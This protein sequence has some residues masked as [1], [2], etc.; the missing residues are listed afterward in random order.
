MEFHVSRFARDKYQFDSTL[1]SLEGN[2]I[3]ANFHAARIFAQKINLKRNLRQFPEN[4]IKASQLNAL[5]LIDEIFHYV[6]SLYRSQRNPKLFE[7]AYDY[8]A[9]KLANPRLDDAL[10]QFSEEFPVNDVYK[11]K[12]SSQDYL[13][14]STE[15]IPNKAVILEELLI[16]WVTNNNPATEP[17]QE[18]FDD[19]SLNKN[20]IY[21]KIIATLEEY[22]KTQP[23]FG[24]DNQDI[25]TLLRSPALAVPHSL[26]GQL[27]FIRSKWG[28]F[29]GSY[30]YRLLSSLD[31][32]KEEEKAAFTGD[33]GGSSPL[34]DFSASYDLDQ[35]KFSP[36]K[37]WMPKVVMMAKNTYVWLDQL[38]K[39]YQRPIHHL[40][41]IPDEELDLLAQN[42]FTGLWLI[43]LWERST[44]SKEIKQRCGNP[45][46]VAS[47]YSLARYSIA[48]DLGGDEALARLKERAWQRG[49]RLAS[50]MV[51]NH[52]GIDSDWVMDHPDWFISL[53]YPPFPSYSF[54][55]QNLSNND[56]V[57]IYLEDHYYSRSDASV[58]FKR[59]DFWSGQEKFIYHGNDGTSMPWND[60]AQLNYLNREVREAVIQTILEVARRFPVI[61]F[62]AAMTL[63]KKHYQR[64]WFPQPGT[65]GDIPS[66][67]EF[68]MPRETFDEVFPVEFWREVVDRVASEVPDTLLLA[69]AFWMMEG[70]FVRTLG[71]HRVYN[72]AFMNML[73]NEDNAKYRQLI[74]NTLEYDPQ[75]LKRYVNFMNN[76]DEK[77]AVEQFGKG[78]K[79]FGICTVM[80]T[81]PGLPMFGHG[82]IE[83]FAEKYGMEYYRAYWDE[84]PDQHLIHRHHQE[85]FPLARKRYIFAEVENFW[86]F[87]LF[88]PEGFVS[89][90]VFAYTNR[91]GN[92][93][94]LT[95]YNNRFG[96]TRGWVKASAAR[97]NKST[98]SLEQTDLYHAL[99]LSGGG[100][101]IVLFRDHQ[102]G[103]EYIRSSEEI[104][105][106]GLYVE[107]NAYQSH[108]FIG[109]HEVEDDQWNQYAK[110]HQFIGGSGVPSIEEALKAL[111]LAPI[112]RPLN[113]LFNLEITRQ[114]TTLMTETD[115]KVQLDW[116]NLMADKYAWLLDE[117]KKMVGG[118][119]PGKPQVDVFKNNLLSILT[120]NK[121][122]EGAGIK[123]FATAQKYI[124]TQ[125][126][127][128]PFGIVVLYAWA[129]AHNLGSCLSTEDY[130]EISR[131][132]FDE[133]NISRVFGDVFR[134]AGM[135][136]KADY[137]LNLLRLMITYQNWYADLKTIKPALLVETWLSDP[138]MQGFLA[139]NRYKDILWFNQENFDTL[140]AWLLIVAQLKIKSAVGYTQT[141]LVEKT[142]SIFELIQKLRKEAAKSE[143]QIEKLLD[144]LK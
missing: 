9:A 120:I 91:S 98:G 82:Q 85:I 53:D 134:T 34:L 5:G 11:S 101:H 41:Q 75:I 70:Y 83:G 124:Q 24:P 4:S 72:S 79:Y 141:I 139:I 28:A 93:S 90:D 27:E 1:F 19:S 128:Q 137:W 44:A 68:A 71:M 105:H 13:T 69:E 133:W 121:P 23:F 100:N 12:L 30:L 55:G 129:I 95:L 48:Y 8:L 142:F 65:G 38:T 58:V 10:L 117:I 113:E 22:F 78:D 87:D 40:D 108:V 50:D 84:T 92:E 35:E 63:A 106:N 33:F 110:L 60:T 77:T 15:G 122:L 111:I 126:K 88:T 119:Q 49:I 20:S 59:V 56:H 46:A 104:R 45:D 6:L 54:N 37:D 132:W 96:A 26:S 29:L 31:M 109:F 89:E 127:Q 102:T 76:P 112:H 43:G 47:A 135:T 114:L 32:I 21:N 61:R 94:A 14:G 73:R 17:F 36:D 57:G 116:V 107:L 7:D 130:A 143:F 125:L 66:R 67:A 51:P 62:D 103:L 123:K 97:L 80:V 39:K 16:L 131:S 18:L 115:Q 52:M 25:V 138:M 42:G 136:E 74:K 144:G 99:G 140:L 86:L 81:M 3:F 118:D 64:L 2:V